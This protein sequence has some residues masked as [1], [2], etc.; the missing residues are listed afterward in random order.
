MIDAT[1]QSFV[2]AFVG[3]AIVVVDN[4]WRY[5]L[6]WGW[7]GIS[8]PSITIIATKS[9]VDVAHFLRVPNKLANR[10]KQAQISWFTIPSYSLLH[11]SYGLCTFRVFACLFYLGNMFLSRASFA[12]NVCSRNVPAI[13]GT[14]RSIHCLPKQ[15]SS[16]RYQQP[17]GLGQSLNISNN[18][19][20]IWRKSSCLNE[21]KVWF[22]M[23]KH[24]YLNVHFQRPFSSKSEPNTSALVEEEDDILY[25]S[26][27]I[28]TRSSDRAILDSYA[29]FV[30]TAAKH[31]EVEISKM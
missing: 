27:Q 15:S 19:H 30:S 18:N 22:W 25:K 21:L 4:D 26:I 13:G 10:T 1:F 12:L 2:D 17:A 8:V 3:D 31:L 5:S 16:S 6:G 20:A 9:F 11:G 28:E 14:V 24:I 7:L 23:V 29:Q